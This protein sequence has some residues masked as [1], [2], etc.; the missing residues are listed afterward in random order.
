MQKVIL[1]AIVSL[2][3]FVNPVL[4]QITPDAT[5]RTS[6]SGGCSGTGGS[7]LINDGSQRGNHLFHSFRQFSLP[8]KDTATFIVS[9]SVRN[10]IIRVTG[11]GPE[12]ISNINGEIST[13]NS[14]LQQS[15]PVNVFILNPNGIIFGPQ[16]ILNIS[17][18]FFGTTAGRIRFQDGAQLDT[19]ETIP[20]L[21]DSQINGLQFE[22]KIGDIRV[23][24]SFLFAESG[25][26]LALV[27]G[28]L[29]FF[30]AF[31]Q[32]PEGRIELGS[33]AGEG[34]V[35]LL[36]ITQ[37][38]RLDYTKF[39]NFANIKLSDT[40]IQGSGSPS[41]DIQVQASNL[42]LSDNS[43]IFTQGFEKDG[44]QIT[45]SA[46]GILEASTGSF[47]STTNIG[48][49]RAGDILLEVGTLNLREKASIVAQGNTGG[50]GNLSIFASDTVNLF[51][52]SKLGTDSLAGDSGGQLLIKTGN[53]NIIGDAVVDSGSFSGKS[54]S[55]IINATGTVLLQNRATLSS[56]SFFGT[57]GDID[58]KA[59]NFKLQDGS[60]LFTSTFGSEPAGNVTIEASDRIDIIGGSSSVITQTLGSGNSGNIK[61]TT[62]LLTIRDG[63]QITAT[64]L[65]TSSGDGG[66]ISIHAN[67]IEVKGARN[68]LSRSSIESK[69]DGT[70]KA[71]LIKIR[72]NSLTILDGAQIS[73][74]TL[75]SGTG[76]NIRI[77]SSNIEVSGKSSDGLASEIT[78]E[79][80][81]FG[82]QTAGNITIETQKLLLS[83]QGQI[84][85]RSQQ[86]GNAGNID[87][88]ASF[89]KLE[90]KAKIIA[91]TD[92]G[93]GGNIILNISDQLLLRKESK[94]ST[95]AGLIDAGGNGGNIT[96]NA[97]NA[98]IIAIAR[99][100]SDIAAN[101]FI[102]NGGRV[103]IVSRGIFGL[104]F[105]PKPT[106]FSDITASSTFGI[107]GS[108]NL[109]A[110]DNSGIQ[111]SLN[112]LPKSAI[113]TEKLVSQTCIV[114][115]N[116]PTGTFYILGKTNL[117]QR[118]GDLIPSN[119]ST[120]E[121][122]TQTANR[123]WQKGDPIVEPQGFYKLANGRLVMSRECDR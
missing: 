23:N 54:G 110:P 94:I 14:A 117:P 70:G 84:N 80:I 4:A 75:G 62:N 42:T 6:V 98:F 99:E 22:G 74:S 56:F 77:S 92:S 16:A 8:N 15:Q 34:I 114:R 88:V 53:L 55:L 18:S 38:W 11:R 122:P 40:F 9:P 1:G 19:R 10:A 32:A 85:S 95:T 61:L 59:K 90:D 35:G 66:D 104:K 121:S 58:I 113:D 20:I 17:G 93:E 103:N 36:P 46:K 33:L 106:E 72:S 71:G 118:P 5:L 30:S 107:S 101:A 39:P 116:Q 91:E 25:K 87:I 109:N 105:Q 81:G 63:G 44:G 65:L 3:G 89:V 96:L 100:N 76:G 2:F 69:T 48:D 83:N 21:T 102:G 57:G 73:T 37:G 108:V 50:G 13:V 64:A 7:C 79:N 97:A 111:N 31:L 60:Q 82:S 47:I 115:Q 67:S 112:Q 12:A 43:R 51:P 41:G 45:I 27:G 29:T 49:G 28:N 120:Q 119:Y 68:F 123:P 52:T 26:T 24:Q 78:T 86:Q